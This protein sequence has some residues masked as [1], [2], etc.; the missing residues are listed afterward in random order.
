MAENFAFA[1]VTLTREGI[2]DE[3]RR[4]SAG[5]VFCKFLWVKFHS[6]SR[7]TAEAFGVIF[8][9]YIVQYK[10]IVLLLR[11]AI[12]QFTFVPSNIFNKECFLDNRR[13]IYTHRKF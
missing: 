1:K 6:K 13:K 3:I 12:I 9:S 11:K 7:L 8:Y 10:N 5:N 2:S 4:N